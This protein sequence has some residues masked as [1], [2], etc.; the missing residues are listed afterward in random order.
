MEKKHPIVVKKAKQVEALGIQC[1]F[2]GTD[3][4]PFALSYSADALL[5]L[6]V[7]EPFSLLRIEWLLA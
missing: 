7:K 5:V 2:F 4:Y 3:E 1:L 6:Y